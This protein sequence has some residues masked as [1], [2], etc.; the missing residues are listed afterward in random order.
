MDHGEIVSGDQEIATVFNSYFSTISSSL[1]ISRWNL[2]FIPSSDDTVINALNKF[3]DHP[4]V[5]IIRNRISSECFLNFHHFSEAEVH[6]EI[7]HLD[8]AK[9]VSG[10][11]PIRVLKAS[12]KEI[13]PI[14][15]RC[16]NKSL[17]DGV[18]PC[19][20]NLAD[21]IPVHKKGFKTDKSNYRPVSLLPALSK[22]F[23]KLVQ[24]Q[25]LQFMQNKLSRYL[26]GFRKGYSTQYALL[27][28]LQS[29]QSTLANGR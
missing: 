3:K 19:E 16:F 7:L 10:V 29:W 12:V 14:L 22:I 17:E 23:E 8:A 4:S 13:T 1:P 20:L 26:C 18:F 2:N 24:K 5:I 11:F 28:L 6:H 27:H 9:K 25:L 15:T 21:V